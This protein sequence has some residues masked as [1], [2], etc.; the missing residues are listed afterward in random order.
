MELWLKER[1]PSGYGDVVR[2]EDPSFHM[3]RRWEPRG[4][5]SE[6]LSIKALGRRYTPHRAWRDD[7]VNCARDKSGGRGGSIQSRSGVLQQAMI[8]GLGTVT[9]DAEQ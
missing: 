8:T 4:R 7:T 9:T 3:R 6:N 2:P 5:A 1:W